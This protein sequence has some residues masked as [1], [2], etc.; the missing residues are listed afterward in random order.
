MIGRRKRVL[1]SRACKLLAALGCVALVGAITGCQTLGY[2]GQAIRGECQILAHRQPIKELLANAKTSPELKEKFRLV[3]QAREFAEK[4]L[5]LP[6]DDQYL[7][8]VDVHRRYVVWNVHAAPEFSLEPKAWWYPFVGRLKYRGYFSESGARRYAA[9]LEKKG[10]GVY[11]EG[12]VAYSTLGWFKDPLLNTFITEP[13]SDLAEILFHELAHQ[14]IFI[15]GDTDFNEAFATAVG[16]EGV[17]RWLGAKTAQDEYNK[18]FAAL[19]RNEQFVQIV[20]AAREKLRDLYRDK[21]STEGLRQNRPPKRQD[22]A[23]LG[24]QRDQI[25]AQLREEYA[26]LKSDWGGISDYDKWFSKP[27]NNAQLNTISTYYDLVPGFRALLQKNGG[28]LEK[29]YTEVRVLGKLKKSERH[30]R[31]KALQTN[32]ERN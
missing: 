24:P 20:M 17:R 4:Q 27:L 31:V 18:Y 12:V 2:Y 26:R 9:S 16:E 32:E 14:R 11:V 21:A 10:W 30:Q 6:A 23:L 5:G 22:S 7:R 13:D 19:K 15:G 3:L 8:Y 1:S 25:I 28:D 29:F